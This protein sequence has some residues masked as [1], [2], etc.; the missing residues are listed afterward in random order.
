ML[1]F[2]EHLLNPS[3]EQK[4]MLGIII[5][6]KIQA[7]IQNSHILFGEMTYIKSGIIVIRPVK[8]PICD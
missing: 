4:N 6:N 2:N 3:S 5:T 8:V 1:S 7:P